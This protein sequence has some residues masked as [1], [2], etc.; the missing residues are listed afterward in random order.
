MINFKQYIDE[1]DSVMDQITKLSQKK[2]EADQARKIINGRHNRREQRR[3]FGKIQ[4]ELDAKKGDLHSIEKVLAEQ[5]VL[6]VAQ[7]MDDYLQ[8]LADLATPE[9]I[10]QM[11]KTPEVS[12]IVLQKVKAVLLDRQGEEYHHVHIQYK[13]LREYIC[14]G[15]AHNVNTRA[16]AYLAVGEEGVEKLKNGKMPSEYSGHHII[17][18]IT[19][20][21]IGDEHK[22]VSLKEFINDI[23]N[24]VIIASHDKKSRNAH[25]FLES[26]L[27]WAQ[28]QEEPGSQRTLYLPRPLFPIYPPIRKGYF[29]IENIRAELER[30]ETGITEQISK[31][32]LQV[33]GNRIL[34]FSETIQHQSYRVPKRFYEYMEIFK[35]SFE[36]SVDRKMDLNQALS[37]ASAKVAKE[38]LSAGWVNGEKLSPEHVAKSPI[39][40]IP[41]GLS[42]IQA[43]Q[44]YLSPPHLDILVRIKQNN[45][46]VFKLNG[47][48]EKKGSNHNTERHHDR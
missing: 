36:G 5:T 39:P 30:C 16:L 21:I 4:D 38:Y 28:K 17:P 26:V 32:W 14:R 22:E 33:W 13:A 23:Y 15:M 44:S 42:F 2:I 46:R 20:A 9:M 34:A 27:I 24:I 12:G 45:G 43:R 25:L 37:I 41:D 18:K 3:N 19:K 6:G 47:K 40:V 48:A 8:W 11:R 31:D 10:R 7:M 1:I 35:E 29:S